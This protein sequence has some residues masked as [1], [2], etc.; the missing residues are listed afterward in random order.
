MKLELEYHGASAIVNEVGKARVAFATNQLRDPTFFNGVLGQPLVFREALAALYSVVVSDYKY[1]PKDRLE[2]HAW[3]EEQDRKF[4]QNLG[5]HDKQVQGRIAMLEARLASAS[6]TPR[7]SSGGA[8]STR[9]AGR[10][11]TTCTPTSTSWITSSI[12]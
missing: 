10:T 3:L 1:H 7:A 11:S 9:P 4:L 12:R 6:S 8:R 5:V 2:F